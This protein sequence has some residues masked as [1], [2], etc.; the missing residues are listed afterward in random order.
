VNE[1][2]IRDILAERLAR[3]GVEGVQ[4]INP[5]R[6]RFHDTRWSVVLRDGGDAPRAAHVLKRTPG[7]EDIRR[8]RRTAPVLTFVV[9]RGAV[10]RL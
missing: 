5:P 8:A 3:A 10:H 6:V 4:A 1:D 7:V 9:E 2:E